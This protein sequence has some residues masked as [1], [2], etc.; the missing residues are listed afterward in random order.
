MSFL[1]KMFQRP[2]YAYCVYHSANLGRRLGYKAVSVAEF[3]VAGGNGLVLLEQY[4]AEVSAELG[5]DI[6]VYGF[7][8]AKG[9]PAPEDYRDL[10]Y[11]WKEGFFH[12]DEE[13]L[14]RRLTSAKLVLGDI[15]DTSR[16][17]F[18]DYNPAPLA[19]VFHDLDF[20][21]STRAALNMFHAN[22]KFRL[23]RIF[24]FFDDIFG[25]EIS[26]YNDWTGERLAIHEF[27][28]SSATK[29]ISPAYHLH[30]RPDLGWG[31]YIYI[32]HDFAH[33]RYNSFVSEENQQLRLQ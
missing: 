18:E 32:Q 5:I 23:P 12:M 29:K 10:P 8:T 15:R 27:N 16:T 3:G 19:A 13:A 33:S 24:C 30:I 26:L 14:R 2:Y 4:A 17:F 22:E 11:H 20:Y 6:E 1:E 21:S 31:R 25:D 9:L 28:A 7:D